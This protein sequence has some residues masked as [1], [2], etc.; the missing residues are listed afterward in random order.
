MTKIEKMFHHSSSSGR[1]EG[2]RKGS[3]IAVGFTRPWT[4]GY[5]RGQDIGK[6]EDNGELGVWEGQK[7]SVVYG[8]VSERWGVGANRWHLSDK[9]G[10]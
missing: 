9:C 1:F 10:K 5:G 2:F 6:C 8:R 7:L 4:R 3:V